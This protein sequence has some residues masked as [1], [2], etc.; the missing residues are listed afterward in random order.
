[1]TDNEHQLNQTISEDYNQAKSFANNAINVA[2]AVGKNRRNIPVRNTPTRPTALNNAPVRPVSDIKEGKD[3]E[4]PEP[5]NE[6][7]D[8]KET[9]LH[10]D[11]SLQENDSHGNPPVPV[12]NRDSHQSNGGGPVVPSKL[13]TGTQTRNNSNTNRSLNQNPNLD[14]LQSG[15]HYQD[16]KKPPLYQNEGGGS[17]H[18]VSSSLPNDNDSKSDGKENA[19][20]APKEKR[21]DATDSGPSHFSAKEQSQ[22]ASARSANNAR[23]NQAEQAQAQAAN[24][25]K[26]S[27]A[28]AAKGAA[29]AAASEGAK[30]GG[31]A[32]TEAAAQG[33]A[34]KAASNAPI[35]EDK[36]ALIVL[37]GVI[38]LLV[39][40]IIFFVIM[41]GG[42]T[43]T[44]ATIVNYSADN[45]IITGGDENPLYTG[46]TKEPIFLEDPFVFTGAAEDNKSDIDEV[47]EK[48]YE[49]WC[50]TVY[51][52]AEEENKRR[53]EWNR[54]HPAEEQLRL[55]DLPR[56][57]LRIRE[58]TKDIVYELLNYAEFIDVINQNG[59]L[60]TLESNDIDLTTILEE[61][62][63]SL[64]YRLKTEDRIDDDGTYYLGGIVRKFNL[65]RL[66]KFANVD[67]YA[68]H[69]SYEVFY[70]REFLDVQDYYLRAFAPFVDF[71]PD[72][73]TPWTD[74]FDE[75]LEEFE[76]PEYETDETW[77]ELKELLY[78]GD[79]S[80]AQRV[81][82]ER[83]L[84]K[85]GMT[86][87]QATRMNEGSYDCSS[88]IY[89]V[90][91][92][93]GFQ[94]PGYSSW[95]PVA[96]EECRLFE[97]WGTSLPKGSALQPGDV[98]FYSSKA[99]GRYKNITHVGF[100]AG[101]GMMID[102]RGTK[103]GVVYRPLQ[104]NYVSAT[105]PLANWGG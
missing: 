17:A 70:N 9:S 103:Y 59:L 13:N 102:A 25:Q 40:F 46:E 54:N 48:A 44:P 79:L 75:D 29:A 52:M 97:S 88:L 84:T 78:N 28:E 61:G 68:A 23:K 15:S 50:R 12:E 19:D 5:V 14:N 4:A 83:A 104:N 16:F 100:Y 67:A 47:L 42:N 66:Y 81:V 49:H 26:A 11:E 99:N 69:H 20:N 58:I 71:G 91:R 24:A 60:Y 90:F 33:A 37:I 92:E 86:Y 89:R 51:T 72:I 22:Q 77:E 80:D 39:F 10:G 63:I 21:D 41:I 45:Y 87:S 76:Q 93:A 6:N 95:A 105:R 55:Y 98:V 62:D 38:I 101:N 35:P 64:L 94:I 2:K 31:K 96:A 3:L 7:G 53:E 8:A 82:I 74:E 34:S 1:M 57:W 18:S 65:K 73:R 85:I 27:Q 30:E 32:A 56:T 43:T 36:K